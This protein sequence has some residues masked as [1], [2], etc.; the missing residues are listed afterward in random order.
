MQTFAKAIIGLAAL[1]LVVA[2][3]P[4]AMM[5]TNLLLTIVIFGLMEISG[6]IRGPQA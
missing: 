1:A 6:R 2:F 3:S 5:V 4:A